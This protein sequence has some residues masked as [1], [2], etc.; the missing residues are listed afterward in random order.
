MRNVVLIVAIG[1]LTV[2]ASSVF[3]STVGAQSATPKLSLVVYGETVDGKFVFV[4]TEILIPQVPIVL[5][6]TFANNESAGSG[7]VHTFTINDADG[8]QRIDSGLLSPQEN[9]TFEFTIETMDKILFNGT[10]FV[11]EKGNRGILYYCIPHRPVGML[12]EIVLASAGGGTAAAE[13]GVLL[14]AYWIGMIGL[15][16]TALWIGISYFIIK[17]SSPHFKDHREHVRR[18]LP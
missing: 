12:G 18:G 11:P 17:S 15:L 16:S 14:R 6:V 10:S 1:I 13:K 5:N 2:F 7:I 8:S 4:P 9:K 3:V